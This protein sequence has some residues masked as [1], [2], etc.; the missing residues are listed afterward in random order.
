MPQVTSGVAALTAIVALAAA[1]P[2]GA[3][4][5]GRT[6]GAVAGDD[7]HAA[8]AVFPIDG[9]FRIGSSAVQRFGGARQ[10]RG[11][12]ILSRCGTPL[13]AAETGRVREARFQSAAGNFVVIATDRGD[14][15]YMHLQAP[16]LVRRGDRV[17]AGDPLGAVGDTGR[18]TACHLHFE[19]WTPPGWYRGGR[20][21]D[22]IGL[23][24]KLRGKR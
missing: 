24:R 15:V 10:H 17:A 9:A 18:T 19:W 4:G 8:R 12:D 1:A 2:A 13:V 21:T 16:A 6:G 5:E 7:D 22:P 23:L 14:Q 3:S 20:A 11:Q